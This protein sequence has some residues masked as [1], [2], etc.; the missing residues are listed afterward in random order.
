MSKIII[1]QQTPEIAQELLKKPHS[2]E[3]W[4]DDRGPAKLK[5]SYKPML[6]VN[7]DRQ[8]RLRNNR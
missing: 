7:I 3:F 2:V 4:G 1:T 6:Y 8:N 5:E